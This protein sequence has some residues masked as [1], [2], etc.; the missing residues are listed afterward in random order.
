VESILT[1]I[2]IVNEPIDGAL[3]GRPA[4]RQRLVEPAGRRS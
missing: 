2:D 4:I 3:F 1:S